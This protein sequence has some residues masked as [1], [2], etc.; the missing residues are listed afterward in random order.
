[1]DSLIQT[2]ASGDRWASLTALRDLLASQLEDASPRDVAPLSRQLRDVMA[3][4]DS[5]PAQ[6][7]SPVDDLQARRSARREAA[8]PT[9]S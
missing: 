8:R 6:E 1:M 7:V 4:L 3:E 9:G 5:R 2:V